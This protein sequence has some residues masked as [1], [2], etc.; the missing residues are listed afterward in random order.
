[1]PVTTH[2]DLR[3]QLKSALR[4]VRL[5][6][7]YPE[8]RCGAFKHNFCT[9]DESLWSNTVNRLLGAVIRQQRAS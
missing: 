5:S 8:C 7:H 6:R 4:Q 2:T 3:A 9:A 1:M